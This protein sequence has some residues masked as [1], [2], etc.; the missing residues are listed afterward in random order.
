MKKSHLAALRGALAALLCLSAFF[1]CDNG[2]AP[3]DGQPAGRKGVVRVVVDTG[4]EDAAE[5]G[6]SRTAVP[7][8]PEFA[9]TLTFTASGKDEVTVPITGDTGEALL[10]AGVWTL[11]VLGKKNGVTVAESD[12]VTVTIA[13][14]GEPA[15][16]SVTVRP[17]LNGARGTFSYTI[18]ADYALTG[19]SAALTPLD[20]GSAAQSEIS[21]STAGDYSRIVLLAPGYYRLAARAVKG[22][23]TLV[24]REVVHIYSYTTT[25]KDYAL[26]EEDFAPAVYLTGTLTGGVEGYAPTGISAYGDAKCQT[27]IGAGEASGGVWN[28]EVEA[29]PETVYVKVRL[30]KD[31]GAGTNVY[32]SKPFAVSGVSA[33]GRTGI[34]VPVEAYAVIFDANGGVFEGGAASVAMTAPENGTLTPPSAPQ[35]EREFAGWYSASGRFTAETPVEGDMTAYA[36]WLIGLEGVADYLANAQG[37]D[38]PDNPVPLALHENLASGGWAAILSAI[39]SAGKYVALDLS[40]C[41]MSGTEFDPG[42]SDAGADKVAALI[43]PDAALSVKAGTSSYYGNPT[44]KAFTS[45]ASISGAGVE[46]VGRYAFEGCSS[47]TTVSLPAATDIGVYAFGNCTGL[48]SVSLPA[49]TDIGVSAFSSC[50]GLTSVS[51]PAATDIGGEAFYGC[52]SLT[53]VSLPATPPSIADSIF[54][55]TGFYTGTGTIT[56]IVP[57]GAV[58]AYTSAW[59]VSAETPANG[60]TGVYGPNHKA[61]LITDAAQ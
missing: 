18:S 29:P 16:V 17:A 48:T 23:Q 40:G 15:T 41:A 39:E 24:R 14:D 44:F 32:Y 2:F 1:A 38:A 35:S 54:S 5:A 36:G 28:M 6:G 27:D 42:A 43:L 47:L 33:T 51:L 8:N 53:T 59:G 60:A 13:P 50:T 57:S 37:G 3:Q 46:T 55:Y 61:V 58:F 22:S 31:G 30:S 7:S 9:Y 52:S 49:A 21:L 26:T 19:V 34:A 11:S 45:L 10:D 12:P 4:L 25:T 56:I 20:V